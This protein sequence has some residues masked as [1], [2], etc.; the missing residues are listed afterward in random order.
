MR[1]AVR[2][3]AVIVAALVC[4]TAI[5]AG[6]QSASG[7][8]WPELD[9]SWRPAEHQ[10]TVLELSS[11]AERE[12]SKREATAGIYQDYLRLPLGYARLGYRYTFS[13]RDASYRESRL[14]GELTLT[15]ALSSLLH[16][17]SRTRL[18]PRWVN[19]E[20]SYRVR[21]RL[22][23]QRGVRPPRPLIP[24]PYATVEVYYDSRYNTIARVGGRV[25]GTMRF[26][27]R[28]SLDL[29]VARQNN[30]RSSPKYVNALGVTVTLAY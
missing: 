18:E 1:S 3:I 2:G 4:A 15:H 8:L 29:Y 19:G 30:S 25:G 7:E 23:L 21:E 9:V 12:G 22:H 5:G 14:V 6:A 28:E 17:A 11:S 20:Y 24:S 13:T 27:G 26:R 16:V 10:R